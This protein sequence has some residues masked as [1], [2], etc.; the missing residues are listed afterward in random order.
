MLVF[1]LSYLKNKNNKNILSEISGYRQNGAVVHS[2]PL[3][4]IRE[5]KKEMNVLQ[6]FLDVTR[7]EPHDVRCVRRSFYAGLHDLLHER[8]QN[9]IKSTRA[10]SKN[11]SE[12]SAMSPLS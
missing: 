2:E 12:P 1:K 10:Q 9:R 4:E 11:K 6:V 3:N 5:N 7:A 8:L